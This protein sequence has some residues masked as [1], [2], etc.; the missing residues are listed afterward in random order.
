LLHNVPTTELIVQERA[1]LFE[2]ER[3]AT[4]LKRRL[5]AE[6]GVREGEQWQVP[7]GRVMLVTGIDVQPYWPTIGQAPWVRVHG[8]LN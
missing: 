3:L 4:E 7:K 8:R 1:A 6:A 2:Y 5:K